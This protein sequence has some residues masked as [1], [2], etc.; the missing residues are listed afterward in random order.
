[1]VHDLLMYCQNCIDNFCICILSCNFHFFSFFF[2]FFRSVW[3]CYQ[4]DGGIIELFQESFLLFNIFKHFEKNRTSLVTQMIKNLPVMKETQIR[5]QDQEDS[6][7]KGM[8][9]HSSI[10][11]WRVLWTEEPGSLQSMESQRVKHD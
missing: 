11:V 10:L 1:M 8:T 9:I 3:F 6:L 5:P 7:E 2:F 4:D